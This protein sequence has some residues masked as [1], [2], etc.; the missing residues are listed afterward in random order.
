ME[1]TDWAPEH[2]AAL[3]EYLA[4][5]MSYSEIARAINAKFDTCYSRNAA[6][7]RAKRMGLGGAARPGDRARLPPKGRQPSLQKVRERYAAM[8]RWLV[9][10]FE[11]VESP[12]L[13]CAD[14]DPRHL[15]LLELESGD[16]RYPYGG[17]EE[18]EPITFC[19]HV[20]REGS[21]YCTAHFHLTRGPGEVQESAADETSLELVEVA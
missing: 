17:D 2:S 21:S 6:L 8:A 9:P 13:R 14:V 16:C 7:G 5:G 1:P 15:S 3:K 4:Q 19:G 20:R 11:P 12:T 10:V 18:G